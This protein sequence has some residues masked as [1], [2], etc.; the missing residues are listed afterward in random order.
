M[1]KILA[2][3]LTDDKNMLSDVLITYGENSTFLTG[4]T[5]YL[6]VVSRDLQERIGST[7]K[8]EVVD[9]MKLTTCTFLNVFCI[10]HFIVL[11]GRLTLFDA[12]AVEIL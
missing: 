6:Y 3:N 1:A 4:T 5:D 12:S 9:E 8:K 10:R 7:L 2:D 11:R